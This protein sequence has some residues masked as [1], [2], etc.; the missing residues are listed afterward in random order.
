M[1]VLIAA[2][3]IVGGITF[4]AQEAQ[5]ETQTLGPGHKTA[6]QKSTSTVPDQRV[7]DTAGSPAPVANETSSSVVSTPQPPTT[8]IG[9]NGESIT[10]PTASVPPAVVETPTPQP[11]DGPT[12]T[13]AP[14]V[15]SPPPTQPSEETTTTTTRPIPNQD[16]PQLDVSV[17]GGSNPEDPLV[18]LDI[19][20]SDTDGYIT[21]IDVTWEAG[22]AP[23]NVATYSGNACDEAPP[24]SQA[25]N[26]QHTYTVSGTHSVSVT[27]TTVSCDGTTQQASRSASVTSGGTTDTTASGEINVEVDLGV[28]L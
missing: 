19:N 8:I 7:V 1:S 10:M 15:S 2:L 18:S 24:S 20:V 21:S 6:S 22:E 27:V 12:T 9:P 26:A 13:A 16:Q 17:A 28:G 3:L 11:S 25:I 5:N 23:E 14:I 4:A